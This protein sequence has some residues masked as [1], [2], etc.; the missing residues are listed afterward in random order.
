MEGKSSLN[1]HK[2]ADNFSLVI[3]TVVW[4]AMGIIVLCLL[5][6]LQV[7]LG[8]RDGIFFN[9]YPF[10]SDDGYDWIYEGIALSDLLQKGKLEPWPIL[11]SPGFVLI[12]TIDAWFRAN[13][14]VILG[15]QVIGTFLALAALVWLAGI[16]RVSALPTLCGL[17]ALYLSPLGQMRLYVLSDALASG[18]LALSVAAYC[19]YRYLRGG[20]VALVVVCLFS[21]GAALVQT[22][23]LIPLLVLSAF[24]LVRDWLRAKPLDLRLV[25]GVFL[26]TFMF[27]SMLWLWTSLI[28]HLD[29]PNQFSLLKLSTAM[30]PFYLR[31]WVF[32]FGLFIPL[33][34][35]SMLQRMSHK[36]SAVIKG[37]AAQS[38]GML[39][40]AFM[41]ITFFYQWEES[42]FTFIYQ[43]V[44]F[45]WILVLL[46]PSVN[47]HDIF[48][49]RIFSSWAISVIAVITCLVYSGLGIVAPFFDGFYVPKWHELAIN[50]SKSWP[51][52]LLTAH[53]QDV[54][55]LSRVCGTTK[56]FC[57]EAEVPEGITPYRR[58]MLTALRSRYLA[59]DR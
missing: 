13:G 38:L 56:R 41:T 12:S 28:P 53:P 29:R 9:S 50:P 14:G 31:T 7:M 16:F 54:F 20:N 15:A 55:G 24:D 27:V 25:I 45:A 59:E 40:L 2:G 32:A 22:Y 49:A 58:M 47:L 17:V 51:G 5:F 11:R 57:K 6:Q 37:G 39:I 19:H 43:P 18:L 26:T 21:L 23:G 8:L 1:N 4:A 52:Q 3:P 34:L 46:A 35:I 42:R 44:F 33:L 36:L 10:I 48:K 30:S